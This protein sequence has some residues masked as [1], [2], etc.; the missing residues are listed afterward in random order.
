[1]APGRRH[2][3]GIPAELHR[4]I[5][6]VERLDRSACR[7]LDRPPFRPRATRCWYSP[8]SPAHP[9]PT[10]TAHRSGSTRR[11]GS[12]FAGHGIRSSPQERHDPH[13]SLPESGFGSTH[14]PRGHRRGR[15]TGLPPEGARVDRDGFLECEFGPLLRVPENRC[16][17]RLGRTA[18]CSPADNIPKRAVAVEFLP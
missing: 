17:P 7:Q 16:L 5:I 15:Q 13:G 1:M 11:Q 9:P 10:R 2:P 4:R 3:A 12:P 14:C 6:S 8:F 18:L